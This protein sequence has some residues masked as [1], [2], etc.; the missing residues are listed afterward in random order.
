MPSQLPDSDMS[1]V[2]QEYN[3]YTNAAFGKALARKLTDLKA[4]TILKEH[5]HCILQDYEARAEEDAENVLRLAW[6]VSFHYPFL[7]L[8]QTCCSIFSGRSKS[9]SVK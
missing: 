6:R 7:A 4:L 8:K 9:S 5:D 2:Y 3:F 1:L